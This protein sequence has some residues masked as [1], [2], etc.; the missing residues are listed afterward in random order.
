MVDIY[1]KLFDNPSQIFKVLAQTRSIYMTIWPLT[2][3]CDLDLW[4]TGLNIEG[5]TSSHNGGHL[6]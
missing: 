4:G 1:G 6:W 2:Y 5:D 3:N